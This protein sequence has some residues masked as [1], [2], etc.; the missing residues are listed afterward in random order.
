MRAE[1]SEV[2]QRRTRLCKRCIGLWI[3]I[4]LAVVGAFTVAQLIWSFIVP[5]T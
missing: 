4:F 3:V 5:V 1:K 2:R